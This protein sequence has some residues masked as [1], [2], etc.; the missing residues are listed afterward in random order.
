MTVTDSNQLRWIF[1]MLV[2]QSE[3]QSESLT[4]SLLSVYLFCFICLFDKDNARLFSSTRVSYKLIFICSPW[5][6]KRE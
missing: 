5:A 2:H 3:E 4:Q 6:G 1:F